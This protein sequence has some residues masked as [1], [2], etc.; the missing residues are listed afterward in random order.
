VGF[1]VALILVGAGNGLLVSQ[2]GTVIM[3]SI[4]AERGSEAG[5]LQGGDTATPTWGKR[6]RVV[7]TT[8]P[9]TETLMSGLADSPLLVLSR[10][11]EG[12]A[13][14]LLSD[15]SWLWARG[16]DGGGPQTEL[17]RRLAHWLMKEPDLEEEALSGRQLGRELTITRRTMATAELKRH[18]AVRAATTLTQW[19][20]W[21]GSLKV[22]EAGMY[23]LM[24]ASCRPWQQ[25]LQAIEAQDI[26]APPAR[27][28]CKAQRAAVWL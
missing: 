3:S 27:T 15:Q 19:G 5:G 13:A 9:E 11:G 17:L 8:A 10:R 26:L 22:D 1:T 12:R 7:E 2:L 16:C 21:Q 18:G 24:T 23:V 14:Q 28:R 25:P 6:F 4:P 20:L